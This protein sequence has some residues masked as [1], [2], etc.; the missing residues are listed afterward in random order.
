LNCCSGAATVS[1]VGAGALLYT[2]ETVRCNATAAAKRPGSRGPAAARDAVCDDQAETKERIEPASARLSRLRRISHARHDAA[3]AR[4][5]PPA[6]AH[7]RSIAHHR[8]PPDRAVQRGRPSPADERK[9]RA[10][11]EP[12]FAGQTEAQTI[13]V[14]RV[15]DL[16]V[17][18]QHRIR[19]RERRRQHDRRAEREAEHEVGEGA[20]RG[21]RHQHRAGG[22]AQRH[23]PMP[24]AQRTAEIRSGREQRNEQREF[25]DALEGNRI[26]ERVE[27]QPPEPPRPQRD[28][29]GEVEHRRAQ[30][31]A[32]NEPAPEVHR[33][34]QGADPDEPEREFHGRA[35]TAALRGAAGASCA[36]SRR[37]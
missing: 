24:S 32:R 13:A 19:R 36:V 18:R 25:E 6:T 27:R 21:D 5:E 26:I 28:A 7:T 23:A 17:T 31:S 4:Y 35:Y 20:E 34:E 2:P 16:D 37:V 30:G 33:D 1:P 11:V 9:G 3:I 15:R 22:E 12:C 29:E 10:V 14:G 8:H